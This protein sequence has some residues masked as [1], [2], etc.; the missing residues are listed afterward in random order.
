[1]SGT[2]WIAL[3][4]AIVAGVAAVAL[5]LA[6]V[7]L[8]RAAAELRRVSAEF[9]AE[10]IP[11]LEAMRRAVRAADYELDRVDALVTGAERVTER[12]DSASRAAY[13]TLSSPVVRAVA[14]GTGT[15]R[16]FSRLFGRG[17]TR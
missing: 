10:A 1:M 4:A 16:M 3:V 14:V 12:A 9:R 11:T 15:R 2:E 5:V 13:R 17:H 6:A 8:A 7:R